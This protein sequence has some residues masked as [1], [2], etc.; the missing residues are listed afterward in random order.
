MVHTTGL[1]DL[2][3]ENQQLRAQVADLLIQNDYMEQYYAAM[4]YGS[5]FS[6]EVDAT[7]DT[8]TK[9][10]EDL[11]SFLKT[12]VNCS[13]TELMQAFC[14]RLVADGD[15]KNVFEK[16]SCSTMITAFQSSERRISVDFRT[17][18]YSDTI[19]WNRDRIYLIRHPV[20]G[21]ICGVVTIQSITAQKE[22][23]L[24][25][26]DRARHDSLTHLCNRSTMEEQV[27]KALSNSSTHHGV[28]LVDI[29]NFKSI[30][31][32]FG[33]QTGDMVLANFAAMLAK[34]FRQSDVVSRIGGDEFLIFM[35]TADPEIVVQRAESIRSACA[36]ILPQNPAIHMSTSIGIA[37]YPQHGTTLKEL[38]INADT[39]LYASKNAG[40]NQ[41]TIYYDGIKKNGQH[42]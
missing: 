2:E 26:I 23:E 32:R 27:T 35:K 36:D 20:S 30:N 9:L 5:L 13:Y 10:P 8:I 19:S 39:A 29:D 1:E 21:H 16:T 4:V 38:Y 34:K 40:K 25:L 18:S 41:V 3:K 28:I 17:K 7:T 33:H 31:D 37:L 11:S 15:A 42:A 24:E 12:G 22:N 14:D 6:Y